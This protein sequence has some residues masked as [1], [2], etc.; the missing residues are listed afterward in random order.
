[1]FLL[2]TF[3]LSVGQNVHHANQYTFIHCSPR[4]LWT[5]ISRIEYSPCILSKWWKGSFNPQRSKGRSIMNPTDDN[6]EW[7]KT[8]TPLWIHDLCALSFNLLRTYSSMW[9]G[10]ESS[11][12]HSTDIQEDR[13]KERWEMTEGRTETEK[14]EN[15]AHLQ[16]IKRINQPSTEN[17]REEK[18]GA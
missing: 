12:V 16:H 8:K 15:T 2:Q 17:E 6:S 18:L 11:S 1:M 10:H 14:R 7:Q 13:E 3:C 9:T 4:F 5:E